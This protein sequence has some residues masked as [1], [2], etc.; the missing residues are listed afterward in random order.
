[1]TSKTGRGR[2]LLRRR[3]RLGE[4]ASCLGE[5]CSVYRFTK[6]FSKAVPDSKSCITSYFTFGLVWMNENIM[7]LV[8]QDMGEQQNDDGPSISLGESSTNPLS[9]LVPPRTNSEGCRDG[10][11][12]LL[13]HPVFQGLGILV[14]ALVVADGALFFFLLIG[15]HRLCR[16]R[17]DCQPRNDWYNASIQI[18]NILFTYMAIVSMPWRT[19]NFLHLT[20]WSCPRRSNDN[21]CNL[22]GIRNAPDIW[23]HLPKTR[24]IGITI[25]L[26]LNAIFQFVNQGTRIY[27][28]NFEAQD[29]F[30]GNLWTNVFFGLSFLCAGI[31]AAWIAY[32]SG[33][34][35]AQK[36]SI[37][38]P[39]P[40]DTIRTYLSRD[41][42][43]D[44]NGPSGY[45]DPTRDPLQRSILIEDR[46]SSRMFAL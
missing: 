44:Q 1:M 25:L 30:P 39:G 20:G 16:P 46:G 36:P 32:E 12:R 5:L 42:C 2:E 4:E 11:L 29:S 14:L 23:F 7:V 24:R 18:L 33:Q 15:G 27:Y 28:P 45:A 19:T 38:G 6:T 9:T 34:V 37:F 35:R 31:A 43:T 17:L 3:R 41:P 13:D 10:L 22:Y 40:L 8:V 21:G 26:L